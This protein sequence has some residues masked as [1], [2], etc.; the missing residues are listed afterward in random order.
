M[1]IEAKA[2]W[3]LAEE[4]NRRAH[5][6]DSRDLNVTRSKNYMLVT[7][8]RREAHR[9]LV[10]RYDHGNAGPKLTYSMPTGAIPGA[11][12]DRELVVSETETGATIFRDG[13]AVM[14]V[15]EI[16]EKLVRLLRASV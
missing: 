5:L 11:P 15:E 10:V 14:S 16:G 7:L 3:Q 9:G 6:E 8:N 4:F 12:R 13:A 1:D 2:F